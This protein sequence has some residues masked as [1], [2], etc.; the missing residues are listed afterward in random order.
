MKVSDISLSVL[1]E[2]LSFILRGPFCA[3]KVSYRDGT[4]VLQRVYFGLNLRGPLHFP[5]LCVEL[6]DCS[7]KGES[8]P[9]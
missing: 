8:H 2:E 5:T 7:P 6:P 3:D 9:L 1:H 4:L